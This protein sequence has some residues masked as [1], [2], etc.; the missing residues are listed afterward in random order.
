[1][2]YI[3]KFDESEI[4]FEALT[5]FG[6]TQD[7]IDDLPQQVIM[8]LLTGQYTPV[9]SL[10]TSNDDGQ[11]VETRARIKLVRETD[12][13]VSLCFAPYWDSAD[14]EDY[15]LE[16]QEKLMNGIVILR[17]EDGRNYYAQLD[18]MTNQVMKV[19]VELIQHNVESFFY[20]G[21]IGGNTKEN[22]LAGQL[23]E[24]RSTQNS[25]IVTVG[26]DLSEEDGIRIVNGDAVVWKEESYRN[27]LAEFNFGTSGC[28]LSDQNGHLSYVPE[29]QYTEEIEEEL[30]R[31]GE[32]N[33]ARTK[34]SQLGR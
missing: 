30:E 14:L 3:D 15:S 28:W 34:M 32:Q 29:D 9:M 16:E 2:E 18:T 13:T 31:T 26:I 23:A 25:D 1:M 20:R 27:D 8:R 12:G 19:P 33:M 6:I 22:V 11:V 21:E 24:I 10:R 4:P 7:M 5:K 17:E